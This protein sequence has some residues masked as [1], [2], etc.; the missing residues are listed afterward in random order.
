METK[1]E[2]KDEIETIDYNDDS[3]DDIDNDTEDFKT[4]DWKD[5]EEEHL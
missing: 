5:Y 2:R 3:E 1:E 4:S